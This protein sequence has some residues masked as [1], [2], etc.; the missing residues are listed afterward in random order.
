MKNEAFK[1]LI[2]GILILA[3]VVSSAETIV[4]ELS[5]E[6]SVNNLGAAN[7][8]IP[9][10]V[11][12]GTAGME[13][14]LSVTYSSRGK[15]GLLGLGFSLTGLSAITRGSASL[16]QD[17]FTDGVDFDDNDRFLLDGKR[18]EIVAV[19]GVPTTNKAYYGNANTEYRTEIESFS[20][21]SAYGQSGNG[22]AYFKVWTKSGL[23]YEYGNSTNSAFRPG[24]NDSVL[25]WAVNKVSDTVGNYMTFTYEATPAGPIISHI[26]Y[27]GNTQ[28]FLNPYNS[29]EFEYEGRQDVALHFF[30]GVLLDQTN[31]LSK[32]IMKHDGA[33]MHDYRLGYATNEAG[34]SVLES[35]Q[36]FFGEGIGADCLPQTRFGYNGLS[37]GTNFTVNTFYSFLTSIVDP[38]DLER[39]ITGDFN[40][41]GMADLVNLNTSSR[42]DCWI[43]LSQGDGTFDIINNYNFLPSSVD[44]YDL[45]QVF[46]GDFN[47]DGMVDLV[48][49]NTNNRSDC[50]VGLSQ[51]D[52]S[53]SV[54]DGYS[55]LPSSIDYDDIERVFTGDF[56]GDGMIDLVNLNTS[57]RYDCWIGLS[58][59]NGPLDVTSSYSFL[60]SAVNHEDIQRVFVDDFNGDGM[61]DLVNLNTSSRSD[62]WIGLSQGDGT[63][64]ITSSYSF[65]PSSIDYEDI[66]HVLLGDFNGDGM[67]DIVNLS[68][69]S[70]SDCWI[71]LSKGD[72]SFFV[73]TGY[74][75]LE[76]YIDPEDVS[77]VFACDFNG[78]GMADL[79]S[80]SADRF[81][82]CW[83]GLSK[84]DG[85]FVVQE[86]YSFLPNTIDPEDVSHLFAE[87]F[88][89]DGMTDLVNLSTNRR[90]DCWIA[91][92]ENHASRVT[93][94][95]QAYQSE[96]I[97]GAVTRI[98]YLPITDTNIYKKGTGAI[99]PIRDIM[100]P[101]Y[102][103]SEI[104]KEN[105]AGDAYLTQYAYRAAREHEHGRG[106]LGFN[107]FISYDVLKNISYAETVSQKFPLTGRQLKKETYYI[108]DPDGDPEDPEYKQLINLVENNWLYDLADGGSLFAYK[109]KSV[110]TRWELGFTNTPISSVTNYYWFDDQDTNSLPLS[111]QPTN[112]CVDITHGN[113]VKSVVDYGSGLKTTT[114]NSYV[115]LITSTKWFLGRIGTSSVTHENSQTNVVRS[116]SFDYDADT[117]L[118]DREVIEPSNTLFELVTD[119]YY[120]AFGN[121][122]NKTL[123]P[124]NLPA[125]AILANEYDTKGRFVE[126]SRNALGHLTSFVNDQDLGK[127]LSS[128]DPNGLVT[129]W[130]YDPTGRTVYEQRPD[131]TV[132]TNSYIWDFTT[133]VTTPLDPSA[134]NSIVQ[135]AAYKL[136]S[137]T[138]GAPPVTKW[139]D[140]Q[141]R[142]IRIQTESADGR[143]VNTDTGYNSIAQPV[144]VS[145]PYFSG[146]TPVWSY[147]EYDG[148]GRPQYVT[149]PD[150]TVSEQI[151]QGL[152]TKAIKD[153]NHRTSGPTP[154]HQVT[155][156]VKNVKDEVLS[157]TD[158]MSNTVT[159]IYDPVGN[160]IQ[161]T[162][163]QNNVIQMSYDIRGNKISQS[164]P[165]MGDWSYT[166]NALDQLVFQQDANS[167][168]IVT[169]YDVLGRATARTNCLMTTTGLVV[170]AVAVWDYDG[171]G[172]GDKLGNLRLEEHRDGSGN[173]INRKRYAYDE[174]SRP[175]LELMNY[176]GKWYYTG[177]TY[178]AYSR[179]R[180]THRCWKPKG[181][182]DDNL[183][184]EWNRFTSVNFYNERG[185]LLEVR[186]T[187]NHTWWEADASDYDQY[188]RLGRY[189]YGNG[190]VT[191]NTFDAYTGH[192]TGSGIQNT[193]QFQVSSFGFSYDR[194]GNLTGRT[195]ARPLLTTLS[196]TNTYDSLN[197][198]LSSSVSGVTN[199][200]TYDALG[201]IKSRSDVGSYLYGIRPHAVDSAGD[202]SY[203]YDSNGNMVYRTQSSQNAMTVRWNSF[204]KP[205]S[206]AVWDS[207]SEFEYS[208]DG[209][210]TKQ[211]FTEDLTNIT[212][213]VY[214]TPAFEMKEVLTNPTETNRTNWVWEMDF[215]RIYVDTP[216]GRIGICQQEGSTNGVGTVTRSYIHKDHLGSVIATSGDS[217]N[218][219]FMSYDAWGQQRDPGDWSP[220]SDPI[221]D[222]SVTDRGFTGHEMLAGLDLI[223][224]NGRIYDPVIGR[225]ISPDPLIQEPNNLQSFN[226]YS[227]V[228]NN[229]LSYHDPSGFAVEG[230][231]AADPA[232][233]GDAGGVEQIVSVAISEKSKLAK[234]READHLMVG[235]DV[236]DVELPGVSDDFYL[237]Y[238]DP[239]YNPFLPPPGVSLDS[240]PPNIA[241]EAQKWG[242][243]AGWVNPAGDAVGALGYLAEGKWTAAGISVA[244]IVGLD[245]L[246]L[247]KKG[248]RAVDAVKLIDNAR[249]PKK[250][251]YIGK[252]ADL[253]GVPRNQ[254]LLPELS[255]DL[256]SPKANYYRNMSKLRGKLREGYEVIDASKFRKLTDPDPTDFWPD[257]TVRQSFLGAERN[258]MENRGFKL[259]LETGL[260]E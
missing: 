66:E 155:T 37:N 209:R 188:G 254:T 70:F 23:I 124:T 63:F 3:G 146:N 180:K 181:K 2:F 166:Y 223:H 210:R 203:T 121:I 8:T 93:K 82:D 168:Q 105:G 6:F 27:T 220:L 53:L 84:G 172:E 62:C 163:P 247:L 222:N 228:W 20:R 45:E 216:A 22:P 81:S 243:R 75:F 7:Y 206:I 190:L 112:L 88:D 113:L 175:I 239:Y 250:T 80:L 58:Q 139:F 134:S 148:L 170:E 154:K 98:D 233:S 215:C 111:T 189:T 145:E 230:T 217:A 79:T 177:L 30:Q 41:D 10:D 48:N 86:G 224:M 118:L 100:E 196:E 126:K 143:S 77:S 127:P 12:P 4:G 89:G 115:D 9:L 184:A 195:H 218:L 144:T 245:A 164:D 165:D 107:Q 199:S 147:T 61:A 108:L 65:L 234:G 1:F 52:G 67:T 68:T 42:S 125:R 49:L 241:K 21:V 137:Q 186:D 110:E 169:A 132:T 212:K 202:C 117:G 25:G 201:N 14:V 227:Y 33:Y 38:E 34:Q 193:S 87:D 60:P 135:T 249:A 141:G 244:S 150:G 120:D 116:S 157:V 102:V 159:Y 248:D 97:H 71:G 18:L 24:A 136:H 225:M 76:S 19:N 253:R 129:Q 242:D 72:G 198:L 16:D 221:T 237:S 162:D 167:N 15:N 258:L 26:D 251:L 131:N 231:G 213:K 235:D 35:L 204:N 94:I 214:A 219:T 5:G 191:T 211:I 11:S 32:I 119:Y 208:V 85:A 226:R 31:R 39:V 73:Q 43:G 99:Y 128:T 149:A 122:T 114:V 232:L 106:F 78:D 197:R 90:S 74:S 178:D 57:S 44:Y 133:T 104:A 29:V 200:A 255:P 151:Y 174:L 96:T 95:T 259:N 101:I 257:R 36:Q 252:N 92:N 83:I 205:K 47:G 50:W 153:S 256:G 185:A 59:T 109:P 173:L 138:D 240:G 130:S 123:A 187:D 161:T 140:K 13:P 260:Y 17:G 28:A 238:T 64:E 46:T 229:P 192:L 183:T 54:Q 158:A 91:L 51:G 236:N 40:G 194:L 176:D 160:L 207:W 156:T 142:E 69:N 179:V 152:T 182:E 56:N 171:Q 55:F 103:V 246:K